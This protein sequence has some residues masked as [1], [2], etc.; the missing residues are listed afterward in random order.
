M[1][2]L[3]LCQKLIEI[4][5]NRGGFSKDKKG[6]NFN[7]VSGTQVLSKI[8]DKMNE[9]NV[10]LVPCIVPNSN[11]SQIFEYDTTNKNGELKHNIDYIIK[12]DMVMRWINADDT[13]DF[14]DVPFLLCGQQDEI[15]KALGSGLTYAERY[16]LMKFFSVPTDA[17]D[18]DNKQD[19]KSYSKTVSDK[20]VFRLYKIA[21]EKGIGT[22]TV[23]EQI[24]REL[25]KT[26]EQLTRKEYDNIVARIEKK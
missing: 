19:D 4:R 14:L 7:Y 15:S 18:P 3:N 5:K 17:D 6:F 21:N 12:A 25:H 20:Q 16:F 8:I 9:L 26:P 11:Q 22:D 23:K 10:L 2:E 13:Y 1:S 24:L